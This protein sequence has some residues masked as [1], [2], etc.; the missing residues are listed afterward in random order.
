MILII[1][2]VFTH[3]LHFVSGQ[4]DGRSR[5]PRD[6]GRAS[7][8]G[9]L[10]HHS[11]QHSAVSGTFRYVTYITVDLPYK[12]NVREQLPYFFHRMLFYIEHSYIESRLYYLSG[13]I[14]M[15][16]IF[17]MWSF[18]QEPLLCGFVF[19][20]FQVLSPSFYL[21]GYICYLTFPVIIFTIWED[22]IVKI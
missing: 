5:H 4:P 18:P 21:I 15:W 3:Y 9:P 11:T 2:V 22:G 17:Y 7:G 20:L 6:H 10:A 19:I 16:C 8:V 14:W 12:N 13:A 1:Y